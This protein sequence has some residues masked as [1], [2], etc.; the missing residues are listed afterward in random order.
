MERISNEALL[1]KTAQGPDERSKAERTGDIRVNGAAE[2][3]R[4]RESER[5]SF[6][7]VEAP[8]PEVGDT[9]FA[10]TENPK[11]FRIP[12]IF[13]LKRKR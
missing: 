4:E 8:A 10:A 12:T 2:R 7:P 5:F 3:R 11:L 6:L 13:D 1:R 9:P